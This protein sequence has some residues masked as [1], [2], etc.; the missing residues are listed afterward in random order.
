MKND[1]AFPQDMESH[2][3]KPGLSKR[4]YFAAMALQSLNME[5]WVYPDFEF[6]AARCVKLADAIILELEK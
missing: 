3:S 4:E 6:I 5:S 1:P 2:G